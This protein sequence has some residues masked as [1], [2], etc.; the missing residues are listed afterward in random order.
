MLRPGVLLALPLTGL[1]SMRFYTQISPYASILAT[2]V[3]WSLL[4]L[5]F[6]QLDHACFWARYQ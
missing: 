6:H 3:A 1:L 5:D 4:G 2:K